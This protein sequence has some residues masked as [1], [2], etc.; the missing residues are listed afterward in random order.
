MIMPNQQA[1]DAKS[2]ISEIYKRY[3]T[4]DKIVLKGFANTVRLNLQNFPSSG[5]FIIEFIQNAD[6]A[7]S[8]SFQLD[9]SDSLIEI[10]NDGKPFSKEDVESIC[11]SASSGK[12]PEYNLGYLGV[13]FKSC[14]KISN[15]PQIRSGAYSFK[16][17]REVIADP[18]L[19]Y[20][21]M[22]IWVGANIETNVTSFKLPL[23]ND[24]K[25]KQII[26]NQLESEVISGKLLLFLKNL[27]EI[28]ITSTIDGKTIKK[29]IR[30]VTVPGTASDYEVYQTQEES[31]SK[32]T[33]NR[34]AVFKKTYDVPETIKNDEV[35]R[36]FKRDEV[37]KREVLIAFELDEKGG[38]VL[39]RGS[40]HFGVY[41]FLPLRDVSTTF[42]FIMQGDFL[43]NP[44]RSDI[45]REAAWNVWTAEC[46]YDLI[47]KSCIPAF[48]KNEKW[49]YQV[50]NV[51]YAET[52][53]NEII[54]KR[55]IE[56]L[57]NHLKTNPV[58][59]D[60][61]GRLASM[62]E[63]IDISNDIT[64]LLGIEEV[65]NAYGAVPLDPNVEYAPGLGGIRE[66]PDS[67]TSFMDSK[68]AATLF[69]NKAKS[70]DTK[71]FEDFYLKLIGTAPDDNDLA[72]LQAVPFV[73]TNND[74]AL[75]PR[76]VRIV[77]DTSIPESKLS[78]FEV[79]NKGI[80]ANTTILQFLEDKLKIKQLTMDDVRDLNQYTPE[81]WTALADAEKI[82]FIRYL[83]E[84]PDKL[85]VQL[86]YL[87]L[88]TKDGRWEKPE[89]L[90]IPEEY[91]SEYKIEKLIG[92]GLI[93]ERKP[94]FVSPTLMESGSADKRVWRG[95][96]REKL[97]CDDEKPLKDLAEEVGIESTKRYELSQGCTVEDPRPVGLSMSPG[98]D[99]KSTTP[100]GEI[101]LIE[102]KG[103]KEH[104]TFDMN[105]SPNEYA[106]LN[107][108]RK[109]N[110]R[111]FIYAVKD[112]LDSPIINVLDGE[113]VKTVAPRV[114]LNES[115][116][117]PKGW[118]NI[119]KVRINVL[120]IKTQTESQQPEQNK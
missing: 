8:N 92:L 102:S 19:P 118:K 56:P 116:R 9:A 63:V 57:R 68:E 51:F 28:R 99:L 58:V 119:C 97:K 13:G 101:K 30:K 112:A 29:T 14:F 25:I 44:G 83:K 43:T 89:L 103:T 21:L 34:W 81:E 17:D 114:F 85:T 26:A 60:V 93:K 94:R 53:A 22:P 91:E 1:E 113:E 41:S 66:G 54:N 32:T 95:F 96:L 5:H 4:T 120:E 37:K 45:N 36:Q 74:R 31:G 49:K 90:F 39:E 50:S 2:H 65:K 20:E 109:P 3:E 88:P 46:L 35:T 62:K 18:N 59:F 86:S 82:N 64:D 12:N 47:V 33:S 104:G 77:K 98:Y 108:E 70:K 107:T 79:V 71:W 106:T 38:I 67:I 7:N 15:S 40:I 55:I 72:K 24:V 16:F 87:T 78:E 61:T 11:N 52:S 80:C 105:I 84:H 73:L 42:R 76:A 6:D 117:Y 10:T 115:G 75:S 100:K 110:E 69:A 23:I 111:Y 48:L 27:K